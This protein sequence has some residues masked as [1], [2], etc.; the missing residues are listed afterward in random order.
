MSA[1]AAPGGLPVGAVPESIAEV[2]EKGAP[3]AEEE[4]GE[5]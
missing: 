5:R 3:A 1:N 2:E 4:K